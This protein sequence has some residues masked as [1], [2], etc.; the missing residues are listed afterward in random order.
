MGPL[1]YVHT[2]LNEGRIRNVAIIIKRRFLAFRCSNWRNLGMITHI[3]THQ[4]S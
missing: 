1:H 2:T 3:W 4:S